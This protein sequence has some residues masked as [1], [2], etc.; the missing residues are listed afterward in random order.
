MTGRYSWHV[1]A[2]LLA[3]ENLRLGFKTRSDHGGLD[4]PFN[5]WKAESHHS[6]IASHAKA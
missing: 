2:Q 4:Q 3:G 1:L 6:P 5:A